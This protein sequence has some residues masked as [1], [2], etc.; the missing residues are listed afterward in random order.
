MD[1]N[2][3][4]SYTAEELCQRWNRLETQKFSER[5]EKEMDEIERVLLEFYNV[6]AW[7]QN[8]NVTQYR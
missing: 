7:D 4:D 5:L 2:P 6:E 1:T 3:Y 8:G